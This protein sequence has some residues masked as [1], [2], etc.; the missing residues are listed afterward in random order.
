MFALVPGAAQLPA[1]L[2]TSRA[3][4]P[5]AKPAREGMRDAARR[6]YQPAQGPQGGRV[7]DLIV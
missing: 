4:V 3:L 2:P 6:Y 1:R 7:I 5:V